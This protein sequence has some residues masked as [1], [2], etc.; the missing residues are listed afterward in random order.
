MTGKAK[1]T[2]A[3]SLGVMGAG[4]AATLPFAGA[5]PWVAF[6]QSGF[7]AGLVGG[8]AD[9]FAV[10]ALFRHPMGIP[11]PHTALLPKNRD[12]VTKAFIN[13][14]EEDLLSKESIRKKA[15][16][17][18]I[19]SR[20]LTGAEQ[21]LE[22]PEVQQAL[23]KLSE[24]LLEQIPVEQTVAFVEAEIRARLAAMDTRR[25]VEFIIEHAV[26]KEYDEKA[27]DFVLDITEQFVYREETRD[28]LGAMASQA[29]GQ[30]QTGGFMSF[31]INAFAGFLSD[32]KLGAMIQGFLL[33]ALGDLRRQEDS[34][35]RAILQTIRHKL[36]QI[37]E[38]PQTLEAIDE[39]KEKL[40][41]EWK[42]TEQLQGL[43]ER[44]KEM[45]L[46]WVRSERFLAMVLPLI[47]QLLQKFRDDE[48]LL[49]RLEGYVQGQLGRWVEDN[50]HKIGVLIQENVSRF[51]NDTLI[52]LMEDKVG[53]DLQW[54]R[55]NGAICGFL[56]GLVLEG[57]RAVV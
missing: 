30:M 38:D 39:W 12:R 26:A 17:W 13:V 35:R 3:V 20:M 7:E 4:F 11:I 44:L 5:A 36:Q 46:E 18:R 48:E 33:K 37:G 21:Q 9:W 31:A 6:L 15:Q 45:A 24:R 43:A 25:A 54:I 1:Y 55:V 51:D 42:L 28:R 49:G 57:I 56:I 16:E 40:L 23:Q 14:I 22:K 19:V 2:A 29:I 41:S 50:H 53:N 8:L 34:N 10:T 27:F 47:S 32:D 52:H